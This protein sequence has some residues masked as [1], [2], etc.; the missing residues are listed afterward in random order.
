[1]R[2]VALWGEQFAE[3]RSEN[4]FTILTPSYVK[5]F[6]NL[7]GREVNEYWQAALLTGNSTDNPA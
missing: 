3:K 5:L 6:E 7:K 1:M 2:K 4:L